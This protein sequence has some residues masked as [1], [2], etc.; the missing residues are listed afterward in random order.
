MNDT[1]I[2][3]ITFSIRNEWVTRSISLN[4]RWWLTQM[5]PIVRKLVT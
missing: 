4:I 1:T 3:N 5:T 2:R